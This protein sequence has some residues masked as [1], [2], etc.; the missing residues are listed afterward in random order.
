[1]KSGESLDALFNGALKI[2][3]S[4]TGYRFSVDALL[5]AHF[6]TVKRHDRVMDLGTGNG[7]IA[8]ILAYSHPG[9]KIAGVEYQKALADRATRN[10]EL[11]QLAARVSL[12]RGDVRYAASIGTVASFDL[13]VCNPPYRRRVGG[14][15]SPNDEKQIARHEIHGELDDFVKAGAFLL[16]TKGRMAL[17]Y[18]A[19]RA[20]DLL[21]SLRQAELEPKRLRMVHSFACSKASLV[22]VEAVKHGRSGVEMMPPLIVY[23]AE[24]EYTKAVA[25]MIAGKP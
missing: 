21:A 6:A 15:V 13:V 23:R 24:K 4:R 17:V 25:A 2:N 22:L 14:R 1:M 18:L 20:V 12:C 19:E 7:V 11:N 5:L 9:I 8:L 10:V 3:Q 16:H